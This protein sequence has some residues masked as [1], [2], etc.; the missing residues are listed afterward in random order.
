VHVKPSY[1]VRGLPG[2][3]I[4]PPLTDATIGTFTFA[5]IAAVL[6]KLGVAEEAF[7]KAWWLALVVGLIAYAATAATGWIDWFQISPGTPLKRTATI[8]ALANIG[9]GALFGLAAIVGHGDYEDGAVAA[10]PFLLTLVGF[11]GL[12]AGG[13]LGGT[14]VFVHGMRVLE[15]QDE[16]TRRATA[17]VPH[18]EKEIA[19]ES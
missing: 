1:L 11:V 16:L 10:L 8:H 12:T 14:I 5:T 19:D 7:A 18:P 2:H 17:P 6:S 15:L 9:A 4:H 13:W 3:P